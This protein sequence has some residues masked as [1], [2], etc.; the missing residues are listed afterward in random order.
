M[1][2]ARFV[3]GMWSFRP[4][5][6]AKRYTGSFVT[7]SSRCITFGG[8]HPSGGWWLN[9]IQML[10]G[11]SCATSRYQNVGKGVSDPIFVG[12]FT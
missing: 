1:E 2:G 8:L 9:R 3:S 4:P 7:Q 12:A 10:S 5:V 11:A 6:A